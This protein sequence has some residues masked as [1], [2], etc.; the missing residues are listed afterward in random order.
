[1]RIAFA[2]VAV[3]G[4]A[5][6]TVAETPPEFKLM[7]SEKIGELRI[8]LSEADVKKALPGQPARGRDQ[9]WGADNAYHQK[10]TYKQQGL[11]LSMRSDKKGGAKVLESIQ[12]TGKCALKSARGIGV[13]SPLADVQK[14]YAAEFNKEESK[15][16]VF[17]AGTIYGGLIFNFKA[18]KVSVMYL[19]AA[20]E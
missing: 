5:V 14:A 4:L 9:L 3:L 17:V 7:M 8:D 19:G 18:D 2:V 13:G 6:P 20:A 16:G 11:A 1:M 12:C 10:W 15:P